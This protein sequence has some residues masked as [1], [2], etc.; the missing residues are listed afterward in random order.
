MLVCVRVSIGVPPGTRNMHGQRPRTFAHR[1]DGDEVVAAL[2]EILGT[3]GETP[4]A[5]YSCMAPTNTN[6]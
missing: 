2:G 1:G 3:D 4:P 6:E 5:S